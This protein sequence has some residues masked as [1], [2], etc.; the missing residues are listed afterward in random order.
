MFRG[1][2]VWGALALFSELIPK[3]GFYIMSIP[4][5]LGALSVSPLTALWELIFFLALN[6]IIGD[7]VMP[8]L[9]SSTMNIHPVSSIFLL[10]AMGSA[11]G[12]TGALMATPL[13]AIIKAFY[14]E[15]YV[16]KFNEDTDL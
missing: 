2:L 13:A 3:I 15:F 7:F 1:A 6:E 16:K 8:K 11:F 12:L 4:P 9:R 10:L 14:E 5:V